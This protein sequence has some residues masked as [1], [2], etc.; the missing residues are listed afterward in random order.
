L[1]VFSASEETIADTGEA[2]S[3]AKLSRHVERALAK[4]A[5]SAGS[6]VHIDAF[7]GVIVLTGIAEDGAERSAVEAAVL[8]APEVE[9]VVQEL[10]TAYP[11][12]PQP[13]PAEIAREAVRQLRLSSEV[14]DP[15]IKVVFEHGW[16]RLEGIANSRKAGDDAVRSLRGIKGSRGV[17]DELRI[18]APAT[19]QF[20]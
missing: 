8:G 11:S 9:A 10:E 7:D 14:S 4:I 12:Q 20:H 13:T 2:D 3:D 15:G 16:L 19:A 18:I 17:I 6:R 5:L 1:K